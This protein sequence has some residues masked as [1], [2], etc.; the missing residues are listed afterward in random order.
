MEEPWEEPTTK[1]TTILTTTGNSRLKKWKGFGLI[2][3]PTSTGKTTLILHM[4]NK[5]LGVLY[6]EVVNWLYSKEAWQKQSL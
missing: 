3:S 4:C 2:V 1:D 5:F 6:I